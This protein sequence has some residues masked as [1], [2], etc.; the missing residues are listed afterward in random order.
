MNVVVTG[1]N[2]GIG[3]AVSAELARRGHRVVVVARDA[4][5]GEQALR[6]L[7]GE[8]ELVVGDLSTVAGMRGVAERLAEVCPRI[9]VLVHNAGLWPS[10]LTLTPDG[11][12]ESFAVNHLAP[13]TL[14][15]LLEDRL[16]RVVQVSAGLYVKGKADPGRT[17]HGADFHPLRTYADTKLCNVAVLPLFAERWRAR[18][19]TIDAVHPGVINTGLGARSGPVG[20]LLKAAKRFWKTP[21]QG[22]A[23]V[24][25]LTEGSTTGRYF[26]EF[27]E[28]PMHV[29]RELGLRLWEQAEKLSGIA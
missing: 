22:A 18:G 17:P 8:A 2:R 14:N 6:S 3:Y 19:G 1:G 21:D 13:F 5:R 23:P 10:R 26:N 9:D 7:P 15:R 24:V 29:D 11:L 25:A 27:E 12:E 16:A 20:L 28:I 4:A